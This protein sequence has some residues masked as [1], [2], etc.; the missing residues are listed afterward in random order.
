MGVSA[1]AGKVYVAYGDSITKG[2]CEA[3]EQGF[4]PLLA[5]ILPAPD[6]VVINA[7]I[8]RAFSND[9][10]SRINMV[11]GNYPEATHYLIQFGT[12][13][14]LADPSI[15]VFSYRENMRHIIQT[16]L[17][18][19]KRPLIAKVPII[20]GRD[21]NQLP[22]D[23]NSPST[24]AA[25]HRI[26]EYNQVIDEL[27]SEYSLECV[28]RQLLTA[29]DFYSYFESTEVD[30]DRKSVEFSDCVHPNHVGYQSMAE[31]WSAACTIRP[32]RP[33]TRQWW[34]DFIWW[35]PWL[36]ALAITVAVIRRMIVRM[37]R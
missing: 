28:P 34:E 22:C 26:G 11:L 24:Q 36:V 33:D 35:I 20:Y 31:M 14:A 3:N 8:Y 5:A 7:G 23:W 9:G 32:M 1:N 6:N 17:D 2:C 16:V 30:A 15:D 18:A 25:N 13:D 12:N 19:G 27:I 4:P 21:W 10:A 37:R 29:P